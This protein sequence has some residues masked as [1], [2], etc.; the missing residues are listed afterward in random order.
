MAG[1]LGTRLRPLTLTTPKPLLPVAGRPMVEHVLD[2]ARE[3]GTTEAVLTVHH[4]APSIRAWLGDGSDHGLVIRYAT[5]DRPLGTAGGV[6][7]ALEHDLEHSVLVLSGDAVSDIDLSAVIERH[8]QSN[9]SLTMALTRRDD[10]REFGLVDIDDRG[11]VRRFQEKP[12]WGEVF[13]NLISTGIY[14]VSPEVLRRIPDGP[15]DWSSDVVPGL[16]RDRVSVMG[17]ITDGYWEDVGD[18]DSYARVQSDALAG[19]VRLRLPGADRGDGVHIGDGTEISPGAQIEAPAVIG[20]RVV[21]EP[22]VVVRAGSVVGDNALI[23]RGALLER[24]IVMSGVTIGPDAHLRGAI[25]GAETRVGAR[26]RIEDSA[27]VS[28]HCTLEPEVEV[29]SRSMVFP[30]KVVE[31]GA[32]VRGTTLWDT[33]VHRET[34]TTR[35]VTGDM[36]T[37]VSPDVVVRVCQAVASRLNPHVVVVVSHDGSDA[38][39]AYARIAAG[40]LV[41]AGSVVR[42]LGA[43]PV[44]VARYDTSLHAHAAIHL[45]RSRTDRSGLDLLVFGQN[46]ADITAAEA[47]HL[48]RLFDRRES[49]RNVPGQVGRLERP[50]QVLEPYADH[51]RRAVART[52]PPADPPMVVVMDAAEAGVADI[53]ERIL[54]QSPVRVVRHDVA[55]R[56]TLH[57]QDGMVAPALDDERWESLSASVVEHRAALGIAIDASGERISLIDEEGGL[58]DDDRALLVV[59]DLAAAEH[60]RGY[61]VLPITAS[62]TAERIADFHDISVHR[63]PRE[64]VFSQRGEGLLVAGDGEGGISVPG[65]EGFPDAVASAVAIICWIARTGLPLG[66]VDARIPRRARWHFDVEMPWNRVGAVMSILR[67]D[68]PG[69]ADDGQGLRF[70]GPDDSW[71]HVTPH[72]HAPRLLVWVESADD[73][74]GAVLV[75]DWTRRILDLSRAGSDVL[76]GD[77]S[78]D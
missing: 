52:L 60:R 44:P 34:I 10:P 43:V 68:A 18:L 7:A 40:T 39:I 36:G 53:V 12:G 75:D 55:A 25:I 38:A 74:Q 26:S 65:I 63:V 35:G 9:A 21:V 46:G 5:E 27:V 19:R 57:E 50:D 71:V 8:R 51:V 24:A 61:V 54:E 66:G 59:A 30:A 42:D 67:D 11:R 45:R 37:E 28:D 6:R 29:T 2:L 56:P 41:A 3:H 4:L 73:H 70:V 62:D 32:V 58:L 64:Q 78:D 77:G 15:V 22:G 33:R 69:S 17:V 23:R 47:R 31:A 49:R 48:Q 14:V 16:L 76:A 72:P 13:G 1:G 20:A